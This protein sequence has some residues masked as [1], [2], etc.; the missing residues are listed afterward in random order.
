[1]NTFDYSWKLA[2]LD[3]KRTY[4][5]EDQFLFMTDAH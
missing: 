2:Y 4:L 1:M 5:E 3:K